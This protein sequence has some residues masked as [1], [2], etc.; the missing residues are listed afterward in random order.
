M[1]IE[2]FKKKFY[3]FIANERLQIFSFS[4]APAKLSL[5]RTLRRKK[6]LLNNFH[7]IIE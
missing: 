3:L 2:M 7:E 4:S 1:S 5:S 6:Y